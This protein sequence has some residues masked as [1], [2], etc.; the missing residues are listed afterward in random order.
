MKKL[1]I[2]TQSFSIL[3][4]NNY[5][6]VD[7]T[8][9][10]Y[11]M[12]ED[13]RIYFLS[14][15]RRFGKSLLISII[16]E[17]FEGLFIYD[18]WNWEEIYPVI[19]LD[20]TNLNFDTSDR[21]ELSLNLILEDITEENGV[22]LPDNDFYSYKFMTLIKKISEKTGQRVVVLIDEYDKPIIDNISKKDVF[23]GNH[24][25]LRSFYNVFKGTDK[26]IKFIFITGVSKF[27]NMSLF[28]SLNSHKDITLNK[29]FACIC[30]YTHQELKDNFKSYL[31]N[32]KDELSLSYEETIRKVNYWYDGYSWM[33]KI[34]FITHFQ[35]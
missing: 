17:L 12:I 30:G 27:A 28:S 6:Y 25:I 14:R 35:H 1:P 15:S 2:G 5:L 9:Y 11:N 31:N 18:K 19:H 24:D 29:V 22:K 34:R 20:F 10:I 16:E 32:L 8:K 26:Y 33:G 3:R 4:K 7:K 13:G 21:L 23:N